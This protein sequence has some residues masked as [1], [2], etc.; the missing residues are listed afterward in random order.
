MYVL[1]DMS[2]YT[3]EQQGFRYWMDRLINCVKNSPILPR[4]SVRMIMIMKI[5]IIIIIM[6]ILSVVCMIMVNGCNELPT[7]RIDSFPF[8]S[9]FL[10]LF[11]DLTTSE[12]YRGN[13]RMWL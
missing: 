13:S 10:Y 4:Q 12:N 9:Q 11:L 3:H 6:I 5:V 1:P 2:A 8:F 7:W